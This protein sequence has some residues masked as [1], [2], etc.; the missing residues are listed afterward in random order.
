MVPAGN[1]PLLESLLAVDVRFRFGAVF[2]ETRLSPWTACGPWVIC[3]G[4]GARRV[5]RIAAQAGPDEG[6]GGPLRPLL[7]K[8]VFMGFVESLEW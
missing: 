3:P 4:L 2:T 7:Q 6:R 8:P 1:A 5:G